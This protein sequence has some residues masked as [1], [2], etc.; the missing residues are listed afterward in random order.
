[1]H[2]LWVSTCACEREREK[3]RRVSVQ[4]SKSLSLSPI[5]PSSSLSTLTVNHSLSLS[6][7]LY[8]SISDPISSSVSIIITIP[9]PSFYPCISSSPLL[10]SKH[11]LW[12]PTWGQLW[13][14]N[15]TTMGWFPYLC[16]KGIDLMYLSYLLHHSEI[17]T[18]MKEIFV[19]F[20]HICK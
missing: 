20:F 6:L 15:F 7:P 14:S 19:I 9:P 2:F 4:V 11:D 17:L 16:V 1:M 13:H 18:Y 5:S 8:L 10:P 12:K 3:G